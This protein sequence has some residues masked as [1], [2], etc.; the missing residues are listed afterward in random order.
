MTNIW[1]L[2]LQ[3]LSVSLVAVLLLV[4]K[5]L[6]R[7]KL[8]PRW[9]YGV[10]GV[11]ALRIVLPVRL[12]GND[13]LLPL[14]LWLETAKGVAEGSLHSAYVPMGSVCWQSFCGMGSPMGGC[15]GCSAAAAPYLRRRSG[16]WTP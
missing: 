6:L 10:W 4:V 16:G 1:E 8:S 5:G 7:D 15:G 11:L 12:M 3:T 14:P 9:Q 2:L 13:I